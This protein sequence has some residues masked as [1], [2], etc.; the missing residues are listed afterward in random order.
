MYTTRRGRPQKAVKKML[1]EAINPQG[2]TSPS[3][4][5]RDARAFASQRQARLSLKGEFFF[6]AVTL[7]QWNTV[8]PVHRAMLFLFGLR[9]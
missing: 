5:S 6:I 9:F 1:E 3:K 7:A 2:V 8:M 4:A